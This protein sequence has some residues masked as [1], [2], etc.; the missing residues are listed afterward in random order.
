VFAEKQRPEPL[1][2][3]INAWQQLLNIIYQ[4]SVQ[5]KVFNQFVK[6]LGAP[7]TVVLLE[8]QEPLISG[9]GLQFLVPSLK[10]HFLDEKKRFNRIPTRLIGEQAI[11]I[12]RYGYR[13]VDSLECP[14]ES[15]A[16]K[17]K[18][19]ALS[20]IVLSLQNA[21]LLFNKISAT[22]AEL[23]ELEEI[24]KQY[25]NLLCLFF[26]NHVNVTCWTVGYAIPYHA[27]KLYDTYKVGYGIISQQGKE[28]KHSAVKNDLQLSN[29]SNS[30]EES[31]KWWQVMRANYVRSVYLP[32]HQPVPQTYKSHFKS[33]IPPHCISEDVCNC[34]RT[35]EEGSDICCV[36]LESNDVIN[37]AEHQ[38]LSPHL[39]QILKPYVCSEAECGLRFADCVDLK[40]HESLHNRG[41][42]SWSTKNLQQMS[43]GELKTEL[44][45]RNL[46][47]GG[48][49]DILIKRLESSLW[50]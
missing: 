6:V 33:R 14:E 7:P 15:P 29:R 28:A 36:C 45:R 22:R 34:G 21:C 8:D 43:V 3:E 19:L 25:F 5:R 38:E 37:S 49:K 13:L 42:T 20:Q 26:P 46:S 24:C 1:H 9:C 11:A 10:E 44:K 27:L 31:G 23:L 30:T 4:E 40:A 41:T 48:K 2:C 35:K 50:V 47:T 18:R 39:I 17:V 16:E 12:A 32:E